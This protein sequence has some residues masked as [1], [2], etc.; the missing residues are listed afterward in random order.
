MSNR[1]NSSYD[2]LERYLEQQPAVIATLMSQDMRQ[3]DK[4]ICTLTESD[5]SNAE[6]VV[7]V[8]HPLQ[9][10]TTIICDARQPTISMVIPMKNKI[11]ASMKGIECD[12]ELVRNVKSTMSQDVEKRYEDIQDFLLESTALDPRFHSLPMLDEHC[13]DDVVQ[14]VT[15]THEAMQAG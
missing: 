8:L 5:V 15:T 3:R 4:D 10:I 7:R 12:S 11:I 9:T 2:M 14:K 6:D 1:W 13:Q